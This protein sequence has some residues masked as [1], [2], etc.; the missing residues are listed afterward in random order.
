VLFQPIDDKTQ[1]V[2]VYV[3]GN[4]I[5]DE[6]KIPENL[7]R[8]W[9]PSGSLLDANI[10][11]AWIY[12]RGKSLDEVCPDHLKEAWDNVSRKMRAYK[13][14]FDI[15]KID[16]R[17][18]CFFDLV[19]HDALLEFCE[20]RN[21]I[22]EYVFE[23]YEKPENY[24][25]ACSA[26]KLLYKIKYQDLF[27]DSSECRS[28]FVSSGLRNASQKILNGQKHIDYNLFGTVTGRLS[29]R[30]QSFPILT[31]KRELRRLIKPHN[32]WFLSFDYNGAEVRTLLA[33]SDQKQPVGDIH[34]WNIRNVFEEPE[35]PREEAKTIFFAW[36]Y[37]PESD[38]INTNYYDRKKVL[39]KY[40]DGDYINTI[41][42]RHIKVDEWRAFNYLIQST[43]AD[44]VIDRAV[45]IDRML[46]GR[47]SFI[48][49]IVH[50]EIV[51]DF[52]DE[53]RELLTE[54]KETFAANKLGIFMVNLKAGKNYYDLENLVL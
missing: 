37:N 45:A 41:F 31:M 39:D 12:A 10:E 19:P 52:D 27:L 5:F 8:T 51:I 2:G 33:L 17:N 46:E 6:N 25:Y 47:K 49:H 22:T 15:A 38:S 44:L 20:I 18:H 1:C 30:S 9:R 50:D 14:S 36:L 40:Y 3:D 4:L 29:T 48:S 53:D 43:T 54:I 32:D 35:M 13:K 21:Q 42:G 11:Y 26:A 16:L 7:T 34:E 23:N 28:L 24:E